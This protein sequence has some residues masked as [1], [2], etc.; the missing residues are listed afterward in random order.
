MT[1]S[2][3]LIRMKLGG[4]HDCTIVDSD[5]Y[6]TAGLAHPS[7]RVFAGIGRPAVCVAGGNDRL[8]ESPDGGPI[9]IDGIADLHFG[10]LTVVPG[11]SLPPQC[12]APLKIDASERRAEPFPGLQH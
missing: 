11:R 7:G 9:P 8:Q 10:I 1:A 2:R 5:E 12:S 4:S 6:L 3:R